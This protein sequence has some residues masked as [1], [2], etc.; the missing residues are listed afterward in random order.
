AHA[1]GGEVGYERSD[2]VET[3]IAIELDPISCP[4]DR[5]ERQR[6]ARLA[7]PVEAAPAA[8]PRPLRRSAHVEAPARPREM[9][10]AASRRR[11]S[12]ASDSPPTGSLRRQF[13]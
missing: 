9:T 8:P 4:R 12:R 5:R 10:A 1:E 6:H 11:A 3:E 13:G 2:I 7:R